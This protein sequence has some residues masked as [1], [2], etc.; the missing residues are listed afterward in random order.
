MRKTLLVFTAV[1]ILAAVAPA[2]SPLVTLFANNNGLSTA[3]ATQ[4][5]DLKV[6]APSIEITDLAI[7]TS[8]AVSTTVTIHV[9]TGPLTYVGNETKSTLW[10]KIAEGSGIS[11]GVDKPTKITLKAPFKLANGTH[12]VAIHYTDCGVKYTNG[13]GTGPTG[14][15]VYKRAEVELTAG[16]AT[17]GFFTGS[18]FNPRVWNGAISYNTPAAVLTGS[19]ATAKIGTTYPFSLLNANEPKANYGAGSSLGNGPVSIDSRKLGLSLDPLLFASTGGLLPSVFANY[20]GALDT[21]GRG[22]ASLVIPNIAALKGLKIHT[23]FVTVGAS[24]PSGISSISN[25]V[26]FTIQ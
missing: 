12:G 6:I 1:L 14:N 15:Q 26:A 25:T 18:L 2:Q 3:G 20:S 5:F 4:Q 22:K 10:T 17:S 7:N 9:Y 19:G 13:T 23:A 16:V 11:R 24:A 8:T 21:S